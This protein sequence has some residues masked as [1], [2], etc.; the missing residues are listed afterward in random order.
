MDKV[1]VIGVDL[2]DKNHKAVVLAAD[3]AEIERAEVS[4][5]PDHVQEF[6]AQHPGA[7][8]AVESSEQ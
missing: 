3:G 4:N 2:G 1:T 8:L 5:T 6:L 7:L